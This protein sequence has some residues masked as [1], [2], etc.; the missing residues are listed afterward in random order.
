M[1]LYGD[2]V[3]VFDLPIRSAGRGHQTARCHRSSGP[4]ERTEGRYLDPIR[5]RPFIAQRVQKRVDDSHRSDRRGRR[6]PNADLEKLGEA[7]GR[8]RQPIDITTFFCTFCAQGFDSHGDPCGSF[9]PSKSPHLSVCLRALS[10]RRAQFC[11]SFQIYFRRRSFCLRD[12]GAV[13][14]SALSLFTTISSGG[15]Q[16]LA[17][18]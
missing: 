4:R 14:P 1:M 3:R 2:L 17:L 9:E 15:V 11:A 7:A 18:Q 5:D 6:R 10:L 16:Q 13:A 8:P 12:S